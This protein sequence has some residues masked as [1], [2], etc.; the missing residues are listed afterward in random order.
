[1]N[2]LFTLLVIMALFAVILQA[3][4]I[5]DAFFTPVNYRGAFDGTTDWTAGWSEFDPINKTYAAATETLGNGNTTS[6]APFEISG[7]ITLDK[8]K[9]YLLKGWVYVTNGGT[10][11]I[12]AGTI[13]RGDKTTTGSIIVERGG[14]LIA[15]GT[16]AEPIVFTSNQAPGSR[17][18]GDWGG[19]IL[20]GK[21]PVNQ[22]EPKIEGG[23]RSIYGGTDPNDNSGSLKYVRLEFPGVAFVP[24][25]E[26]NGLT[27]GG[28]GAG[29]TLDHIQVSYSGD[30]SYEWFGGTVNAKYLIA[31]KSVDDDFDTDYG[32]AGRVQFAV[33]LRDPNIADV[34]GSNGFESDNYNPG[35]SASNPA[36]D[37][38]YTTA[39]FSNV[40]VLGPLGASGSIDPQFQHGAHLRRNT[41]LQIYNT[42]FAGFPRGI[43]ISDAA[44]A[45]TAGGTLKIENS[46]IAGAKTFF[47]TNAADTARNWRSA[48]EEAWF[49]ATDRENVTYAT[50]AELGF[51]DAFKQTGKPNFLL[52]TGLS[53]GNSPLLRGSYWDGLLNSVTVTPAEAVQ[54]KVFPNP[55]S[56]AIYFLTDLKIKSV[57]VTNIMGQVVKQVNL[58]DN[59][60]SLQNLSIGTYILVLTTEE[61]K[62][63]S[64][65]VVK[66]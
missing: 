22:V 53:T 39:V 42:V 40:S 33:S 9:V 19:I 37:A 14:K 50:V 36:G 10:L 63:Y 30:D 15:N 1:M 26:I 52:A 20:L 47:F 38:P 43:Q 58:T 5:D 56:E 48:D 31:Y 2:K 11:T 61:G 7:N 13:I 12:P 23:P 35:I 17:I 27:L 21:A 55:A 44:I 65:R 32:F 34:S 29:T 6:G 51:I 3:Q 18:S 57:L 59:K 4:T 41:R 60:L 16:E 62:R 8:T 45:N 25:Q 64:Q 54:I 28:V 66:N 49:R 46:A 24:N